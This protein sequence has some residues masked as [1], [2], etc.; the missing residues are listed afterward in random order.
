MLHVIREYALEQLAESEE[1]PVLR[2]V[3]A[4]Y[5]LMLAEQLRPQLDGPE[6]LTIRSL[7]AREHDNLRAA[8]SW[9]LEQGAAETTARLWVALYWFWTVSGHWNEQRQWLTQVL[10]VATELPSRLHAQLLHQ[11]GYF[12]RMQGQYAEA[13]RYLEESLALF[14]SVDDRDGVGKVL[15]ELGALVL[16]Q[17][18]FE[19]A[20]QFLEDSVS[21]LREVGDRTWEVRM[22]IHQSHVPR[23][24]GDYQTSK[25][26]LEQA[27]ALAEGL[28]DS[29]DIA[30]CKAE[31]GWLALMAGQEVRAEALL[32]EALAVQR[33]LKDANCS[34]DS[35]E[36]LGLL[37]L[38]R[39]D[40]GGAR[41]HLEEGLAFYTEIAQHGGIAD[42]QLYLGLAS[43]AAGNIQGAE[44]AYRAELRI[45]RGMEPGL[46][47][48]QRAT[49]GLQALAE[50]ELARGN[51]QRSAR[52]LGASAQVLASVG[53][54][55][56]PLPPRLQAEREARVARAR[57]TLGDIAWEAAFAAGE[58]LSLDDVLAEVLASGS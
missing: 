56:T 57:H 52:L 23:A 28:R 58:A 26:I 38:E 35:L 40:E 53:A 11:A 6:G 13:T 12:V 47:N 39:G 36:S 9:S 32:K 48:K 19:Q 27:L 20:E 24:R 4:A 45:V 46:W 42:I 55:S 34:A 49:A 51:P 31:L 43:F 15:G 16:G 17:G 29:H 10:G 1:A 54:V 22:V 2:R 33:Q 37:A 21:V 18:H 30:M 25:K 14:R 3:H 8:L 7:L 5:Y 50:V 44:D 41:V